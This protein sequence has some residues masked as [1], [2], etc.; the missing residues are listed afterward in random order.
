MKEMFFYIKIKGP[1]CKKFGNHPTQKPLAL[2]ERIIMASTNKG[3]LILDPFMGSGS[4]GI[5]TELAKRQFI[6]IEREKDM[7]DKANEWINKFD[8][9]SYK[10]TYLKGHGFNLLPFGQKTN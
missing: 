9:A 6:G 4:C 7:F 1:S 2:L 3:D 5:A 8:F 10:M